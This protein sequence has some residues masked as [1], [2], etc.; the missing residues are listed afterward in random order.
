MSKGIK[1]TQLQIRISPQEKARIALYAK[2]A[3][4]SLSQWIIDRALPQTQLIFHRLLAD[5]SGGRNTKYLYSEIH[6]L[7]NNATGEEFEMAVSHPPQVALTD[8]H[9]NYIAAMVEYAASQ[10]GQNPP[11]WTFKVKPLKK[12]FFGTDLK[13]LRLHLLTN[14]PSPF[15]RRNI[16]IDSTIGDRV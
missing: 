16:F 15:R 2:R 10:K 7:L 8:F 4:M 14:S 12:P 5:L 1:S 11:P 6:D 9:L 13:S 3:K